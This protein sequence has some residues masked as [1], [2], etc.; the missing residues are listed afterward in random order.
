MSGPGRWCL[1]INGYWYEPLTFLTVDRVLTNLGMFL[2][3]SFPVLGI[4]LGL[5]VHVSPCSRLCFSWG[6]RR[7]QFPRNPHRF[8]RN[9]LFPLSGFVC[10]AAV[11]L[12]DSSG[13]SSPFSKLRL[14]TLESLASSRS[15]NRSL[16][17]IR[18]R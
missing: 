14:L 1:P 5:L 4:A 3:H 13:I 2:I 7:R 6:H 18:D 10:V 15:V 9:Y 17:L 8:N 12:D 11:W 16:A